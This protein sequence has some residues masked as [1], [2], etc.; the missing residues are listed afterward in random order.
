VNDVLDIWHANL[1]E[2]E[3]RIAMAG[4]SA[5]LEMLRLRDNARAEIERIERD[6]PVLW[7]EGVTPETRVGDVL[8][9]KRAD[10]IEIRVRIAVLMRDVEEVRSRIEKLDAIARDME[11]VKS[12]IGIDGSASASYLPYIVIILAV[13][14]LMIG[15]GLVIFTTMRVAP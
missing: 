14:S 15:A 10:I 13:L 11:K 1:D 7:E 9:R 4:G 2:I 8:E 6:G 12:H 3:R 5:P